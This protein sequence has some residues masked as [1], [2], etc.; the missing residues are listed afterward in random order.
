MRWTVYFEY[1]V[2]EEERVLRFVGKFE[3]KRLPC[4]R[5]NRWEDSVFRDLKEIG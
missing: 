4:K 2:G 1:S 3:G 5:R